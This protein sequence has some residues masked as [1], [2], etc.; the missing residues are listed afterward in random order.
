MSCQLLIA[1]RVDPWA[2]HIED[3]EGTSDRLIVARGT[4][5]MKCV[6][7]QYLAAV[8]NLIRDGFRPIRNVVLTFVPDE[9]IGGKDGM[10]TMI[11]YLQK[12]VPPIGIVLDEGLACPEENKCT[13]FYGE[14]TCW[15]FTVTARPYRPRKSLRCQH[16]SG[17][18]YWRC[19]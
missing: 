19:Q 10:G 11:P 14:R 13:I 2:G 1:R 3:I 4:Q 7:I 18:A 12:M 6:C 16:G 5:D 9:E 17:E 8:Y 15:W